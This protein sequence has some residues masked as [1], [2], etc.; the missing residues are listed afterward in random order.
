[1]SVC[2]IAVTVTG[3]RVEIG[4]GQAGNFEPVKAGVLTVATE[5]VPMAGFWLGTQKEPT[6]GFEFELAA[7]MASEFELDR[8][9][10][11]TVPF[12][13]LITGDLDGADLALRQLT[14]T[15]EREENLDFSIPYLSSPPAALVRTGQ[16][17]NDMK[18]AR[19]L[20]WAVPE[21][22]TLDGL[23]EE[24]VRPETIRIGEG[25]IDVLRML[26]DDEVEAAMFDLPVALAVAHASAGE[27]EVA[28]Q[29]ASNE[30][31]AAAMPKG[32]VN[33]EEVNTA[34]R[35]LSTDG[36]ISELAERWLG[37][38]VTS[39]SF[40]VSAVPLIR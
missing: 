11:R 20:S 9:E 39:T 18:A 31:L 34:I 13:G 22:T 15:S 23:L 17:I 12:N 24:T 40:S 2:L 1:M 8:V 26:R 4:S 36:T 6:G 14:P 16:E 35:A 33:V 30:A 10:I 29:F 38:S 21:G 28:A 25:R 7:A 27:F 37:V 19:E 5:R 32:S 3:C